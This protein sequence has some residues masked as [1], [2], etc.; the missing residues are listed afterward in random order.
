MAFFRVGWGDIRHHR[1]KLVVRQSYHYNGNLQANTMTSLY[2]NGPQLNIGLLDSFQFVGTFVI[3]CSNCTWG[4]V[5]PAVC[6]GRVMV[7]SS[8]GN[9]FRVTGLLWGEFTGHPWMPLTR[10]VTQSFGVFFDLR[11]NMLNKWLSKQLRHG[12]FEMPS[13]SLWHYCIK[14][15]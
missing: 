8:N 1:D 13:C 11:L 10:A 6:S 9:I 7:T 3:G 14:I 4:N 2:W 12:W 15:Q 5:S